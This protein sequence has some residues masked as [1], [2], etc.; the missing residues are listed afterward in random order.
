MDLREKGVS[1][2]LLPRVILVGSL[3][4]SNILDRGRQTLEGGGTA[5]TR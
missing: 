1:F 2:R 5:T 4:G 3:S